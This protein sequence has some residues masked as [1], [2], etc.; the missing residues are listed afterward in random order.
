MI[1]QPIVTEENHSSGKRTQSLYDDALTSLREIHELADSTPKGH[2][3]L[4]RFVRDLCAQKHRV[5]LFLGAGCSRSVALDVADEDLP[6]GIERYRPRSW[7]D[8]IDYLWRQLSEHDKHDLESSIR[9]PVSPVP[10]SSTQMNMTQ[11]MAEFDKPLL[12]ELIGK[13]FKQE[14]ERDRLIARAVEPPVGIPR[15]SELL[16]ELL[17]LPFHDIVTTNYDSNI[18]YFLNKKDPSKRFRVI[19]QPFEMCNTLEERDVSRIIYLHGRAGSSPLVFD[20]RDFAR[21]AAMPDGMLKYVISLLGNSHVVYVGFALDD[22]SFNLIEAH[23]RQTHGPYRAESYAFLPGISEAERDD[24]LLRHLR[25]IDYGRKHSNLSRMLKNVNIIR[26]FIGWADPHWSD[27][28]TTDI[29]LRKGLRQ[30]VVGDFERSLDSFRAALAS[31]LF[32][33]RDYP[34]GES[35]GVL[36]DCDDARKLCQIRIR[37]ALSHYKLRS[38]STRQEHAKGMEI[39]IAAGESLVQQ[40]R[41][42][43][44]NNVS[45]FENSLKILRARILYHKGNYGE[46]RDKCREVTQSLNPQVSRLKGIVGKEGIVAHLEEIVGYYYARCLESRI[47][48]QL[49]GSQLGGLD[50]RLGEAKSL[51]TLA[52]EVEA[53]RREIEDSKET[54]SALP[55]WHYYR[56]SIAALHCIL[57]WTAGRHM[58]GC[59]RDVI[60]MKDERHETNLSRLSNGIDLLMNDP[61]PPLDDGWGTSPRWSAMRYRYLCRGYALRWLIANEPSVR[62]PGGD[63]G[64]SDLFLAHETI[65]RSLEETNGPGMERQQVL[66]MLEAA[67]LTILEMFGEQTRLSSGQRQGRNLV[68]GTG[69]CGEYLDAAFHKMGTVA[70]GHAGWLK[71]QGLRLASYFAVLSGPFVDS[72]I[73]TVRHKELREFLRLKNE[74]MRNQVVTGYKDFAREKLRDEHALNDRMDF[75]QTTILS[76]QNELAAI[77]EENASP[78]VSAM[79]MRRSEPAV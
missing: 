70:E 20:R 42:S 76:V 17:L 16:G 24:W 78:T 51:K 75:Y 21:L 58:V 40:L 46:A 2:E 69:A 22:P 34:S 28:D 26:Q 52:S 36:S 11:L 77:P 48:Y 25:I 10:G 71:L 47:S 45:G 67:R 29:Y 7:V 4:I 63:R 39:N 64:A 15:R 41:K 23:V 1:E 60:P 5:V 54:C 61:N 9:N 37:M 14:R 68:C 35:L 74:V 38:V 49:Q 18:E 3:Q 66:N 57:V 79:N 73:A 27:M 31:T 13:Y 43:T 59:S 55:D 72:E 53:Q 65:Q 62:Q 32:W 8:L 12:A 6:D 19:D 50:A 56:N 44:E 33:K 30:Y